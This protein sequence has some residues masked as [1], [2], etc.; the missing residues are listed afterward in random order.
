[1][2]IKNIQ[3]NILINKLII[4]YQ[5]TYNTSDINYN[6]NYKKVLYEI[7][8]FYLLHSL[9]TQEDI[10]INIENVYKQLPIT[11]KRKKS[12]INI[13]KSFDITNFGSIIVIQYN[14]INFTITN[15]KYIILDEHYNPDKHYTYKISSQAI[16]HFLLLTQNYYIY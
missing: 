15:D 9:I 8:N 6:P 7:V 13:K 12:K 14:K 16:H 1:M 10:K 11:I 4:K 3:N 5:D 2:E